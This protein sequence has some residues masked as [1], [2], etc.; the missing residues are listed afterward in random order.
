[1]VYFFMANKPKLQKPKK[2]KVS[3][4]VLTS[5]KIARLARLQHAEKI[6]ANKIG[7]EFKQ[8]LLAKKISKEV[9]NLTNEVE[10]LLAMRKLEQSAINDAKIKALL[11]KGAKKNL[12]FFKKLL[13][14]A[15][16]KNANHKYLEHLRENI[17][18]ALEH[19]ENAENFKF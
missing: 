8:S 16:S 17:T 9:E 11:I 6:R 13:N 1:M 7:N 10:L 19:V 5:E 4:H 18:E 15:V 2:P 3:K 12:A 14:F